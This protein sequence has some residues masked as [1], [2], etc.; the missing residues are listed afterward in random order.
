MSEMFRQVS[1]S[2]SKVA[3][4]ASPHSAPEREM[5]VCPALCFHRRSLSITVH[6]EFHPNKHTVRHPQ[7]TKRQRGQVSDLQGGQKYNS[8]QMDTGI[9]IGKCLLMCP[10]TILEGESMSVLC[11]YIS[12]PPQLA[13]WINELLRRWVMGT[14]CVVWSRPVFQVSS[15]CSLILYFK[16]VYVRTHPYHV[17]RG[18]TAS[19]YRD[20]S[21][22]DSGRE[23]CLNVGLCQL[24]IFYFIF[25][26]AIS[27][28][29]G[30]L[31]YSLFS[32][33]KEAKCVRTALLRESNCRI[34]ALLACSLLSLFGSLCLCTYYSLFLK[35]HWLI[36]LLTQAKAQVLHLLLSHWVGQWIKLLYVST[37]A[38]CLPALSL[39]SRNAE[40]LRLRGVVHMLASSYFPRM[41]QYRE[42]AENE[43]SGNLS[44][45]VSSSR[46]Q[47]VEN[48]L[49]WKLLFF[50][51]S[52]GV[53]FM[54]LFFL[55]LSLCITA[56]TA[57]P[58]QSYVPLR[59]WI[60]AWR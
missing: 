8:K 21:E 39:S 47:P 32:A 2:G 22:A 4:P 45:V 60:W 29:R 50:C 59:F 23:I 52:Q 17:Y 55:L 46:F 43:F 18:M 3:K 36:P 10:K 5:C 42:F 12:W 58:Q 16:E 56:G 30:I 38:L 37:A 34:N 28:Q 11:S 20:L 26:H 27:A 49:C 1:L 53:L 57:G 40:S 48:Y 54:C 33:T 15:S 14:V 9:W 44:L 6:L 19:P 7:G 25:F 35:K 41:R 24:F 31:S 51:L 13:E